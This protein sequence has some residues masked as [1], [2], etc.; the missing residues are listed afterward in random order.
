MEKRS[1]ASK[2]VQNDID[3][4]LKTGDTDGISHRI[5]AFDRLTQEWTQSA[6]RRAG[7]YGLNAIGVA[8]Y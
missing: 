6:S 5:A 7:L 2:Q 4:C 8:L 1:T 3:D